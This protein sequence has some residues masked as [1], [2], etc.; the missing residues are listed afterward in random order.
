MFRF[1]RFAPQ[2]GKTIGRLREIRQ[3][4][5]HSMSLGGRNRF[6]ASDRNWRHKLIQKTN[7]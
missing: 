3:M 4:E 5:N 7:K 2:N 1:V 6:P